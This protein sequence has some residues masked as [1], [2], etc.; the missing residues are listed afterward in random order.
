MKKFFLSKRTAAAAD[1]L[2]ILLFF[3]AFI[4][5][6]TFHWK[7]AHYLIGIQCFVCIIFPPCSTLAGKSVYKEKNDCKNNFPIH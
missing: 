5:S 6:G 2:L 4:V 7:L 1:M 3:A